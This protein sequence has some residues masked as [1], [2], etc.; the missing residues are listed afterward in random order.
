MVESILIRLT[1]GLWLSGR[2][3]NAADMVDTIMSISDDDPELRAQ[4]EPLR[5]YLVRT[6]V[7]MPDWPE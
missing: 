2:D 7:I 6:G 3:D 4:C 5:A 1:K